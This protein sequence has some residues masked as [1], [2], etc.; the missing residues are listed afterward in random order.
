MQLTDK[1]VP[2]HNKQGCMHHPAVMLDAA[3]VLQL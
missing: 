2:V 3:D 1:E